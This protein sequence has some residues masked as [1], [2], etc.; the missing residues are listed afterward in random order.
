M[1]PTRRQSYTARFKL[2]CIKYAKENGNRATARHY[3]INESLVRSWR[4]QEESLRQTK[5]TTK[6]FRGKKA[7]WPVLEDQLAKW[8]LQRRAS[9]QKVNTVDMRLKATAL[10]DELEIGDFYGGAS[11]CQ[12]FMH[13]KLLSVKDGSMGYQTPPTKQREHLSL[14]DSTITCQKTPLDLKENLPRD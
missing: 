8:V 11:W 1:P 2:E 3:S 5:K 13:R 6:A 7:R 12:G 9:H 14:K 4:K 10:A